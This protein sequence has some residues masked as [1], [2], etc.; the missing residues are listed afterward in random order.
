MRVIAPLVLSFLVGCNVTVT[1]PTGGDYNGD[2]RVGFSDLH[3]SRPDAAQVPGGTR[4][5]E[6]RFDDHMDR[7][8]GGSEYERE[9]RR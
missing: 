2:G 1:K 6:D 9:R 5:P 7:Q 3:A 8:K 4:S